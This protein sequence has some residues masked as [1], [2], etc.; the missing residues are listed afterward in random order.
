MSL[1]ADSAAEAAGERVPPWSGVA[2]PVGD[3]LVVPLHVSDTR[4]VSFNPEWEHITHWSSQG[5]DI[6]Y[7]VYQRQ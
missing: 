4:S 7:H 2:V 3:L 5:G 1:T 6:E